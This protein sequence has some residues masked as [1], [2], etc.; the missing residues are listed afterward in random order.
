M[1][2]S[3]T[4]LLGLLLACGSKKDAEPPP[5]KSDP[6]KAEPAK[7]DT[8]KP[9]TA[10]PAINA[11]GAGNVAHARL[12]GDPDAPPAAL[13]LT[14]AAVHDK[15]KPLTKAPWH[16]AGGDWTYLDLVTPGGAKFTAGFKN[17]RNLKGDIEIHLYDFVVYTTDRADG[18]KVVEELAKDLK[19]KVPP[20][21]PEKALTPLQLVLSAMG[22]PSARN[23][24]GSFSGPGTW[25]AGKWT[26]ERADHAAE[27]FFNWSIDEK[28]AEISEKYTPFNDEFVADFAAALRDGLGGSR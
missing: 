27:M 19:T 11:D 22:P 7:P 28:T 26:S 23:A 14:I 13:A 12:G 17:T 4:L 3:A 21:G 16:A 8:A 15:E 25:I 10:K 1:K 2:R 20:K 6:V 9:D 18:A 24:D 5:P